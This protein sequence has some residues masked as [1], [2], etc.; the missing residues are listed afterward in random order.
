MALQDGLARATEQ[1]TR[2]LSMSFGLVI[3]S[4]SSL[5]RDLSFTRGC[6]LVRGYALADLQNGRGTLGHSARLR[7]YQITDRRTEPEIH[8]RGQ[9]DGGCIV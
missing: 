9:I 8:P 2:T 5:P 7:V 4:S 1:V 3:Y 6:R